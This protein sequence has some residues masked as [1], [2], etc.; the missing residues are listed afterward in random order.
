MAAGSI[1]GTGVNAGP[2][3]FVAEPAG[4][5]LAVGPMEARA[6][7]EAERL[8]LTLAPDALPHA[9]T[10]TIAAQAASHVRNGFTTQL[11]WCRGWGCTA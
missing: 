11:H 1:D 6:V 7:G 2:G 9:E 5:G 3:E 8:G 4:E 10:R